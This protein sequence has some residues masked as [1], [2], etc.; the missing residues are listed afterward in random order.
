M[1][2][3]LL[4]VF[5][6]VAA[7]GS[8]SKASERLHCVQSNVTARVRQLENE[9]ETPLFYRKKRRGMALTPAGRVLLE[10][11]NRALHLIRE[12]EIAVRD[13]G[14]VTGALS[15]GSTESTAAVRLPPVLTHYL[16]EYPSVEIT[17]STGTS[18]KLIEK[19]LDY[20]LDGAFVCGPLEHADIEQ[21]PILKEE[22]VIVTD[23]RIQTLEVLGNPT[24]LVF[25]EGCA[26]RAVLENWLRHS[27]IVP[28]K[29][30]ELRTYD[31]ILGCVS[32]G[33]GITMSPR[34][35]ITNLNYAGKVGMHT[36]S[37]DFATIPT[38]FVR[39]KDT[40]MSR[41]MS[42]FVQACLDLYDT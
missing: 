35:L 24:L 9:L 3:G 10:Y 27:G 41:A 13:T 25:P 31:G 15:I 32:A 8:V 22:L 19:V 39:K 28:H 6:A 20:K 29:V 38:I 36:V 17:L 16:R 26:Y 4:R 2:I 11:A 5:Q 33:M 7:E 40:V 1:D 14:E 18:E 21:R 23:I 37:G 34:S 42:A 30:M 12:A